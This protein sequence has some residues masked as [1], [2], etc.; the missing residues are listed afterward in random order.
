MGLILPRWGLILPRIPPPTPVL[1]SAVTNPF[2][3][4]VRTQNTPTPPQNTPFPELNLK[5]GKM[6]YGLGNV[7]SL[8]TPTGQNVWKMGKTFLEVGQKN[9][10][11]YHSTYDIKD[12]IIIDM[13]PCTIFWCHIIWYGSYDIIVWYYD[14]I[15]LWNFYLQYHKFDI[16]GIGLLYHVWYHRLV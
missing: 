15:V 6:N 1:Y 3:G 8:W 2:R 9:I 16:I 12:Q 13:I 7:E 11:S 4:Y 5:V 14:I 10:Y